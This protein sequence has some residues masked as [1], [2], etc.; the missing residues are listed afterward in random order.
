[1]KF[2]VKTVAALLILGTGGA[3]AY[4]R[5]QAWWKARNKPSFR[6]AEAVRGEI[7]AVVNSTGN[8]Q[9]VLR[10]QVGTVVSGPIKKLHVGYNDEVQEDQLMV[11]IDPRIYDAAVARDQAM[12][13]TRKAEVE[14]CTAL[15]EQA[16]HDE[17]R[18]IALREENEDYLSGT[19]MDQF[20]YSHL[21]AKAQLAVANAAVEQ[22]DANLK[23]SLTNLEYTKIKSPVDGIV[24]DQKI[25]EGQTL[26]AQFQTPELFVVA[27]NMREKMRVFA[28]VDEADIGLIREAQQRQQ[29]VQ[30]TVDAYPDDLFEG[31]IYQVRMNPTTTQNVVTYPVVVEA[32]NPE[33]KLLPGMT[34]N[35][36]FEI[37]KREDV[38]KIPNAALR[39]F[40]KA[41]HVREADRKL[42]EG[43]GE[44]NESNEDDAEAGRRSARQTAEA[45]QKRN[46][47][48]V[49]IVDGELLKAVEIVTGLSDYKWT[50]LVSGKIEAGQKLVTGVGAANSPP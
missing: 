50:E 19:E 47:R 11:E 37:D 1:M 7:V 42:L 43:G 12:L 29:K 3:I 22:A 33:L 10:V 20:K 15:C 24:I 41:E 46:R 4:P 14:R 45:N 30:F 18:A 28:S 23:N 17:Q 9:P 39:F 26:A 31:V 8:V 2:P 27:P 38:V 35:L 6:T 36:S 5:V 16:A 48:H 21:A 34:A 32:P 49:W 25:E 13:A 40:P 44:D